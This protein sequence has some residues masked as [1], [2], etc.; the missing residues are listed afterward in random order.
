MKTNHNP[1]LKETGRHARGYFPANYYMMVVKDLEQVLPTHWHEEWE[2]F[3]VVS[4]RMIL[5]LNDI[6]IPMEEGDVV[7]IPSGYVHAGFA[8]D[9][10]PCSYNALVFHSNLLAAPEYD[11]VFQRYIAVMLDGQMELP[12]KLSRE[13]PW[14]S[15][16]ID[17]IH[18][19]YELLQR[20]PSAYELRIK[21]CIFTIFADIYTYSSPNNQSAISSESLNYRA[22]RMRSIYDYIHSNCSGKLTV[23]TL[24]KVVS[25]SPGYLCRFFKDMT[26]RTITEYINH[27]R[28]SQAALLMMSTDK[29]LL[30]VALDAGF[31]NLSYFVNQFKR[32]MG[33]T[34]S[35]FKKAQMEQQEGKGEAE[36]SGN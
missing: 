16:V 26:G 8:V 22:E 35:E 21:A 3:F 1:L 31:N 15:E 33:V 32:Y 25:M 34:P 6:K 24:S 12:Q 11:V 20:Q 9:K 5:H 14:Q 2:F 28:L 17:N 27:Y 30:E 18:R 29:K 10:G 7:F 19:A 4:G 13:I 36:A 23:Q